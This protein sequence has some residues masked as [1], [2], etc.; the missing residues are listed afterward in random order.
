MFL[1]LEI[2]VHGNVRLG[3]TKVRWRKIEG[4]R[5]SSCLMR[6]Q[7]LNIH[8]RIKSGCEILRRLERPIASP[9]DFYSIDITL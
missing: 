4:T 1:S 7:F 9:M 2:N 3:T 8:T 6:S 5:L